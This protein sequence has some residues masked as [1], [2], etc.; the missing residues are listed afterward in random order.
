MRGGE[1]VRVADPTAT[2]SRVRA[3]PIE[4]CALPACSIVLRAGLRLVCGL[5][6]G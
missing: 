5:G 1:R 6:V 2:L 4:R 3:A